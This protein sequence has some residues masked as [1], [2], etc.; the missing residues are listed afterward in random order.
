MSTPHGLSQVVK[1]KLPKRSLNNGRHSYDSRQASKRNPINNDSRPVW[2]LSR[3]LAATGAK[4]LNADFNFLCSILTN[5]SFE[6]LITLPRNIP[7]G[8]KNLL[9]ISCDFHD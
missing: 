4:S 3:A 9:S 8:F 1:P 2:V 5:D 7:S 6:T